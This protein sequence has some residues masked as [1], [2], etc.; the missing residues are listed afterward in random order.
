MSKYIFGLYQLFDENDKE[1][2]ALSEDDE[3]NDNVV[4]Y[5]IRLKEDKEIKLFF[6][7]LLFL[8]SLSPF[9]FMYIEIIRGIITGLIGKW[10]FLANSK[11]LVSCAGTA[12]IAPVP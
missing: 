2:I 7:V 12:I 3:L 11:S 10:N 4:E 1:K 5:Y 6:I 8:I 9:F